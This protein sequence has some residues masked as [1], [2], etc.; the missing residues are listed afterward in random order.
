M[1]YIHSWVDTLLTWGKIIQNRE[2]GWLT[3]DRKTGKYMREQQP[4]WKKIKLLFLFNPL[5]EWIDRT[6]LL[7]YW[8]H[9][10]AERAGKYE[11]SPTSKKQIKAFVDFYGIDMS[12]FEPS[13]I[14][15]Y[16]T[17]QDF[18]IRKHKPGFRPIASPDDKTIATCVADSRLVVYDSL[19]QARSIWIKGHHFTLEN[20]VGAEEPL[21]KWADAAV[22]SFRLSP[23]DYHRYH[24]PVTGHVK[25]YKSIHGDYYA[26]DPLC[27]RSDI[28]VLTSNARCVV[29]IQSEELG[30]VLFVAIGA[31][32]V[33]TVKIHEHFQK[34]GTQVQK[35]DEIGMFEF[36]G[37]SIIVAF[38]KNRIK[39]DHDLVY[40]S[41]RSV[42]VNV[43][44]G[45]T[46]G[47]ATMPGGKS[48]PV[49]HYGCHLKFEE[50][51]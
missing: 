3:V 10:K 44:M 2:V 38:E 48:E 34:P 40:H 8:W 50:M 21:K 26:V 11:S 30:E 51:G 43:E 42:E 37:S 1:S 4:I 32:E 47:K 18:F 25:W 13:D 45:M 14:N 41:N 15:E 16:P 7:R 9:E 28:D 12:Q 27:I 46:L 22:A 39:F 17:F 24:S 5:L 6:K 23:Q 29:A 35:G 36:G 33:G 20:L 31:K 49:G 19:P